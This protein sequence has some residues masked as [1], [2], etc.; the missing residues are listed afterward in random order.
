MINLDAIRWMVRGQ[1]SVMNA[2][3]DIF[4]EE[5]NVSTAKAYCRRCPVVTTCLE[6][7]LEHDEHGVWGGTSDIDRRALRRGGR[8]VTCPSCSFKALYQD[9]NG[10]QICIICGVSWT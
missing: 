9:E 5:G 8:R 4:Y 10:G 1:C 7:A 2:N 3:P 6:W